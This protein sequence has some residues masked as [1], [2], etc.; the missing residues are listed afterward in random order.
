MSPSIRP[1]ILLGL[2][3]MF[4]I[5]FADLTRRRGLVSGGSPFA[6]FL[7]ES[8]FQVAFVI[9]AAFFLQGG[10]QF[11]RATLT[12]APISGF[13]IFV[14][15]VS[16]LVALERIEAN[17]IVPI[18]RLGLVVTFVFATLLFGERLT[19]SRMVGVFLAGV[20]VVLLSLDI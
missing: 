13:L 7:L 11:T 20:A 5:G 1:E 12:Y 8:I 16:L 15:I 17:R 4:A 3:A 2:L 18:A 9:F 19:T 10:F 14:G 6:Y